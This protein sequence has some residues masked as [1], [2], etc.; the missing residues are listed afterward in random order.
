MDPRAKI[1]AL[2]IL[3]V[4]IFLPYSTYAMS[5][6][7]GGFLFAFALILL[8]RAQMSFL[9]LLK[10]LSALWFMLAFLLLIY[11]LVPRTQNW[12]AFSVNGFSVYWD[13]ILEA[14]RILFRL[15]LMIAISMVLTSTTKPLDMTG[16]FEW[17]LYPLKIIGFP[18]HVI[19]MIITLALRFI[20]TILDDVG[21]IM[22]AQT[23]RGV[24]YERGHLVTRLKAI[25]SLIIPLFVSSFVRS[26]DLANAMECRGYDPNAKRTKYRKL[27]FRIW[28]AV[29]TLIVCAFF[30]LCLYLSITGFDAY[31]SFWGLSVI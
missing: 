15:V 28:D 17:Y 7:I 26:D 21:R 29:Q 24:D 30:A 9:S 8:W 27:H 16:A 2:I 31:K 6:T 20:P 12:L 5:F 13:S 18:S 3:M 22:K 4:A 23:S 19:A 1:F 14:G 11:I 10:S 25:I